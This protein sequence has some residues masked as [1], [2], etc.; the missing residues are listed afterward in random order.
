MSEIVF[1]EFE[2]WY[3]RNTHDSDKCKS[4][5]LLLKDAWLEGFSKGLKFER[6]LPN[7]MVIP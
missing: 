5:Y 4:R 3:A 7:Q 2:E 1:P 6:D